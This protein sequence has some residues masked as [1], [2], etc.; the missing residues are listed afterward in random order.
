MTFPIDLVRQEFPSLSIKDD[1]QRR[2][3]FDNPA[4]TQVT[5]KVIDA[6]SDCFL[7]ATANLGGLFKT[8]ALA[9]RVV[10]DAHRAMADFLGTDD[11]GEIVVGAS[12]TAL[13]FHMSRSI[14]RNF[15]PGDEII[16]TR[17]DHEGNV[18]PW[19][20]IAKEKDLVIRWADFNIET[21]QVEPDTILDLIN[22]RTKLIALNYASNMM[23][24]I[25]EVAAI[26]KLAKARDV[27]VYVDAVQLAPHHLIDV[28]ALGCDYLVCSSYKFFGPHLGILWGRRVL[29]EALYP[30]KCRCSD[31]D[32]PWR[33]EIGTPPVEL[34]AGL[35]ACVEHFGW[36]GE[37]VGEVGDRRSKI[38]A[39]F[40]HSIAY[41]DVLV[42]QLLTGL[43]AI[44]GVEI[45][46][47]LSGVNRAPRVP[48][49]SFRHR[50]V[51]PEAIAKSLG[52]TGI[53]VWSGHNY[54][55]EMARTLGIEEEGGVRIGI[56]HYNTKE[57]V[58]AVIEGVKTAIS[59][60]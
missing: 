57:E 20:E 18:S 14:C 37:L 24:A 22:D 9:D 55:Y 7:N 4:G 52:D 58:Q 51:G 13:T 30:Y 49:V 39:G 53:F 5:Q 2:I 1:G 12:T 48:T 40:A 56:A 36:L 43:E 45:Y 46:G 11:M 17:M 44:D 23:G 34:L 54:A 10:I 42:D 6:V 21:W 15:K 33:F 31:N 38:A 8:S 47:P 25:N 35:T 27:L 29:L 59:E 41:E 60:A 19:L 26:T 3:Y 28:K 50:G 32:L 16:V